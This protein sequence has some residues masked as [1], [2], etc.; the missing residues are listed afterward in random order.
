MGEIIKT[1]EVL[2]PLKCELYKLQ[3]PNFQMG[4]IIRGW[5]LNV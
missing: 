1:F 4:E 3:L 2:K 5:R